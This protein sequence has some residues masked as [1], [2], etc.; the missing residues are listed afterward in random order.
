MRAFPRERFSSEVTLTPEAVV[1]FASAAGDDNPI[2]HDEAFAA[3]TRFGRC[4]ASGPHT[5]AL[6]LALTAAHFSKK[7]AMLG[8]E[9]WVRFRRPVYADETIRLEWLV[10]KVTPNEKLKGDVVELRGRIQSRDGKT[11]VGAKG[12][13]LVMDRL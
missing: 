4:T 3:S 2:H 10:V 13:V 5:T 9:F 11:A 12:R 8:L 7:C 6:L 1:A